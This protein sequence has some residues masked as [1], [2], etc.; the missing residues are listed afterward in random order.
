MCCNVLNDSIH[1]IPGRSSNYN[2][3]L[4]FMADWKYHV[5]ADLS[6]SY[7]QIKIAPSQL[8]YMGIMTPHR[9]IRIMNRLSQG[10]LN[11]DV[12]LDQ[13]LGRVL[14][15]EK[16]AGFCC[17]ARDDI[18]VGGNTIDECIAN[19]ETV[20]AKLDKHNLKVKPS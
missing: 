19:W 2:D 10:L 3:I 18:I 1:P 5:F 9:G 6:N 8:K 16:T 11:S 4:T 20:L 17:V 15:D 14:G 7:F 12:H 13:V